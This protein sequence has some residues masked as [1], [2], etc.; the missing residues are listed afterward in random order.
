MAVTNGPKV[1]IDLWAILNLHGVSSVDSAGIDELVRAYILV[2]TKT[3]E[4][5][6]LNPKKR[7]MTYSTSPDSQESSRSSRT[8]PWLFGVLASA[9]DWNLPGARAGILTDITAENRSRKN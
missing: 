5:K 3:S 9:I 1:L 8:R 2:K 4:M 7:F 6:L